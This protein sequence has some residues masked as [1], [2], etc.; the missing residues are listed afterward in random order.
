MTGHPARRTTGAARTAVVATALALSCL[1]GC[2]GDD[3]PSGAASKAESAARSAGAEV[4]GA[5]S[6]LASRGS[7]ALASATAEVGRKL[8][9]IKGGVDVKDAVRLGKPAADGDRTTVQVTAD[10]SAGSTKTFAVQVDFTDQDGSLRDMVLVTVSDV[11]AGASGKAT[12]RSNRE[13]SGEV[14]A[15]VG[16]AV[17]Y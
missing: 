9:D 7:G 12:A 16:R 10:N 6:S 11:A 13:L 4:T 14:R 17:R 15:K 2:S 3:S 1:T 8:D 5:A